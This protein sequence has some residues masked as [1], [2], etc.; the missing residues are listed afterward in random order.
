MEIRS[1]LYFKRVA[2]L[3]HL[4]KAA[5]ELFISQSHLSH[6][7][8]DMEEELGVPLFDRV[9]R[10]IQ[11]TPYGRLFY[12]EITRIFY[13]YENTKTKV[14]EMY[15]KNTTQLTIVTNVS[16]YMPGLLKANMQDSPS[17][18]IQQYS[19]KRRKIIQML[20]TGDADYAICCPILTEEPN[21]ESMLLYKEKGVL[22]YPKNH[23]LSERR[24]VSVKELSNE[25]FI[26]VVSGYGTRDAQDAFFG[27]Y[28]INANYMVETDDTSSVFTFVK[29]GIG[30]AF[31]PKSMTL[32]NSEFRH[33]F[34]EI[35]ESPDATIGLTW[36]K[37]NYQTEAR[38][39][40]VETANKFYGSLV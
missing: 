5:N 35:D 36:H 1:I 30:I 15:K 4:T 22:I 37:G 38:R 3:E 7:I 8:S 32:R 20:K 31:A 19:A 12:D 34:V 27:K 11:L 6:V 23:W 33:Q 21:L 29:E 24:S 14:M 26:S 28:G 39:A 9:G 16:T 40:F 18:S 2:E 17:L 25:H 10:G 13:D